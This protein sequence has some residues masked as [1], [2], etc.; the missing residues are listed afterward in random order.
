VSTLKLPADVTLSPVAQT[1]LEVM[2]RYTV[3]PWP[4]LLAQCRR[5]G[6]DP[7]ALTAAEARPLVPFLAEGVARFTSPLKGEQVKAE[8]LAALR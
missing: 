2:S 5:V 6:A 1:V 4:V 3:F 7:A 8:L